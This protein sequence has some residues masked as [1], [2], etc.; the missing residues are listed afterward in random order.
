[1]TGL[2]VVGLKWPPLPAAVAK[3]IPETELPLG[4]NASVP[5][6]SSDLI[7]FAV[8]CRGGESHLKIVLWGNNASN[9]AM[10]W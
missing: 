4:I 8:P 7:K 9:E 3:F 1:M 5:T 10:F 6:S 2:V